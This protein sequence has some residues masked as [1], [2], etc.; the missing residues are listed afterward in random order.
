MFSGPHRYPTRL[1][2]DIEEQGRWRTVFVEQSEA[3]TWQADKLRE[4][5][6]RRIAFLEGWAMYKKRYG[7]F[8]DWIARLASHDFP[9]A[10]RVRLRHYKQRTPTPEEARSGKHID[11]TYEDTLI[12]TLGSLR[13]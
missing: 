9:Q 3:H 13:T 6:L 2:I 10:T 12:R 7:Q 11:G 4:H 8:A 5:R 1:T